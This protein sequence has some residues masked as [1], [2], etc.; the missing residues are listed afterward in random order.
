[1]QPVMGFQL[2]VAHSILVG[3]FLLLFL[4]PFLECGEMEAQV[5]AD[6][7]VGD[8]ALL[9]E[10]EDGAVVSVEELGYLLCAL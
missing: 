6:A 5:A 10:F 8:F 3:I 7:Q 9:G 2:S 4:D 1:M